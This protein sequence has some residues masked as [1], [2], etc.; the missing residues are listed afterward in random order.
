MKVVLPVRWELIFK[1]RVLLSFIPTSVLHHRRVSPRSLVPYRR[2]REPCLINE[3]VGIAYCVISIDFLDNWDPFLA[4]TA[5]NFVQ[6]STEHL[7]QFC[8]D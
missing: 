6:S 4:N 7:D 1:S 5:A 3:L 8:C 2:G